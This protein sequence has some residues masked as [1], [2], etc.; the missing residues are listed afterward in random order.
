MDVFLSVFDV[1]TLGGLAVEWTTAE[2]VEMFGAIE[3]DGMDNGMDRRGVILHLE[4]DIAIVGIRREVADA[5]VCYTLT[6]LAGT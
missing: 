4:V 1:C 2:V 6:G 3:V 5:I